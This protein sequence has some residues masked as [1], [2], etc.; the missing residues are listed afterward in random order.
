MSNLLSSRTTEAR[1]ADR[2]DLAPID[3]SLA[4]ITRGLRDLHVFVAVVRPRIGDG[5]IGVN[6]SRVGRIVV[7]RK[8]DGCA[9]EVR[10]HALGVDVENGRSMQ[11]GNDGGC[12]EY[13]GKNSCVS[14]VWLCP[15]ARCV[16]A[17]RKLSSSSG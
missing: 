2:Q 15:T 4:L 8:S 1:G 5:P 9:I 16:N 14:H 6:Q 12:C 3:R 13:E 11:P 17:R 7:A 10:P